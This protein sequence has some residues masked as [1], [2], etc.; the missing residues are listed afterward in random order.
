MTNVHALM[1]KEWPGEES[2]IGK[3]RGNVDW[4]ASAA[5]RSRMDRDCVKLVVF[6]IVC[7]LRMVAGPGH[8]GS[9]QVILREE[10]KFGSAHSPR[11]TW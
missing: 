3:C 4:R 9:A 7:G 11:G 6:I 8:S 2:Q 1:T 5:R 10:E